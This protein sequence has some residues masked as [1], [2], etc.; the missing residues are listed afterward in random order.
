M[1]SEL[2]IEALFLE[3]KEMRQELRDLLNSM[4]T[5]LKIG[6][7]LL[8]ALIGWGFHSDRP[9]EN[10]LAIIPSIIV[11]FSAIH[12][13][14]TCS[15]NILGTYCQIL[16]ARIRRQLKSEESVFDWEG[17]EIWTHLTQPVSVVQF[18]F[19][20]IF[21]FILC[22]FGYFSLR[23]YTNFRWTLMLHTVEALVTLGYGVAAV[24]WNLKNG[25]NTWLKRYGLP[26]RKNEEDKEKK[27]RGVRNVGKEIQSGGGV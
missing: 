12:I 10:I 16:S 2:V 26:E 17:S 4:N 11:V 13:L 21:A 9:N 20:L 22:L 7:T 18:G 1:A 27:K 6:A 25:R 19:Y 23:A 3:Y 24:R 8:V 5:N 15:A 14:K